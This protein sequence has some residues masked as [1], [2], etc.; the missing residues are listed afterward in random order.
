MHSIMGAVL[1]H[2]KLDM[3]NFKV[4]HVFTL[5]RKRGFKLRALVKREPRDLK[6]SL[7]INQ[8]KGF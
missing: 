2:F 8:I 1:S 3:I 6:T 7:T 5:K 4:N